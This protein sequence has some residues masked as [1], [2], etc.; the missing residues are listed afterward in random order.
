VHLQ[1]DLFFDFIVSGFVAPWKPESH[2]QN[3]AVM[4]IVGDAAA[5]YADAGYF[6]IV[7]GIVIPKWFLEPL[8]RKLGE[9]GHRVAY[10]VL[11]VPLELCEERRGTIEPGVVAQ[12]WQQFADL[13]ALGDHALEAGDAS[14]ETLATRLANSLGERFLLSP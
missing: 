13:G 1:A 6:T 12:I 7:E 3:D 4:S 14:P 5:A 11:R 2:A 10:A 9:R 8:R